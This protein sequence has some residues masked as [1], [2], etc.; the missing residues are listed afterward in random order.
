MRGVTRRGE[1]KLPRTHRGLSQPTAVEAV[2]ESAAA[3]CL[4][5]SP[6]PPRSCCCRTAILLCFRGRLA[7]A[8]AC[9]MAAPPV[10]VVDVP[11][12][13][14]SSPSNTF[15]R[16]YAHGH[17]FV[18]KNF[19]KPTYCHHCTDLLWGLIGQGYVCEGEY[20]GPLGPRPG[21]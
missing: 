13:P 16:P 6:A 15:N 18:K 4:R 17:F 21:T 9:Q 5:G 8:A 19:H 14:D 7:A 1:H 10:S 11:S 3:E 20:T 12:D 2:A